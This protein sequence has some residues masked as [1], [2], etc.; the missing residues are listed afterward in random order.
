MYLAC[1]KD[2]NLGGSGAEYYR[3][4]VSF[5]QF[6]CWRLSPKETRRRDLWEVIRTWRQNPHGQDKCLHKRSPRKLLCPLHCVTLHQIDSYLGSRPPAHTEPAGTLIWDLPACR[7]VRNTLL[8]FISHPVFVTGAWT[9]Y[10][11]SVHPSLNFLF[12]KM[13]ITFNLKG[14]FQ[15]ENDELYALWKCGIA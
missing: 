10:A 14:N 11:L 12:C 9:D 5:H 4:N 2:V 15:Y 13:E 6:I 3:L 1:E 7:T 8:L